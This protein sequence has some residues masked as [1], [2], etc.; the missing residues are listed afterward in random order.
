MELL[1]I[2]WIPFTSSKYKWWIYRYYCDEAGV[3]LQGENIS[4]ARVIAQYES[5]EA[6]LVAHPTALLSE[7]SKSMMG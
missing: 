5:L 3:K 1:E 4:T 7:K 2:E 6:A